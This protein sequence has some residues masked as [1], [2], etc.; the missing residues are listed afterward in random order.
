MNERNHQGARLAG[1]TAVEVAVLPEEYTLEQKC[2]N[3]SHNAMFIRYALPEECQGKLAIYDLR[4]R[5]VVILDKKMQNAGIHQLIWN[6]Q[7][8]SNAVNFMRLSAGTKTWTLK[9]L[10]IK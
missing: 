3:P 10:L 9:M 2:P 1:E 8:I 5:E 4:E 6:A 7:E